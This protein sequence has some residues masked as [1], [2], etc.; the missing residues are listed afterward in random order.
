MGR[1]ARNINGKVILFANKIT[2][3]MKK[4]MDITTARRKAQQEYNQKHNISPKSVGRR[5]DENL[6]VEDHASLVKY[7]KKDKLPKEEKQKIIKE[8]RKKMNTAAKNLDFEQAAQIRD[9]IEE[10]KKL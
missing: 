5:M 10:I 2:N 6:K 4:A 1:A 8:F 3:S 9:K 7:S